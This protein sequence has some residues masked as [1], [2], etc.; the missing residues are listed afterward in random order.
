MG[1]HQRDR[2]VADVN[3][4]LQRTEH[5]PPNPGPP[6]KEADGRD[7]RPEQ[8]DDWDQEH[9]F[10][11]GRHGEREHG[12]C[13]APSSVTA[14]DRN[15]AA[16]SVIAADRNVSGTTTVATIRS[17]GVRRR[18]PGPFDVIGDVHGCFLELVDLLHRLGYVRH[19]G[20]MTHPHGRR[21]VF[22]G[23]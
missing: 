5:G 20:G 4:T 3:Q 13:T 18:E 7:G 15:M 9:G 2:E 12:A 14:V 11:K 1:A 19:G 23:D 16:S 10:G 8:G 21:A 22:I 6:L 17:A